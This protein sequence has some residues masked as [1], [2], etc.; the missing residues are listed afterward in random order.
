MSS[1]VS[2]IPE[3][4]GTIWEL[5]E[6]VDFE[7]GHILKGKHIPSYVKEY[8]GV[9]FVKTKEVDDD[10]FGVC[11]F[12]A[13]AGPFLHRCRNGNY[14]LINEAGFKN[15]DGIYISLDES[16]DVKPCIE[17]EVYR[18]VRVNPPK[19]NSYVGITTLDNFWSPSVCE[20]ETEPEKKRRQP[21]SGEPEHDEPDPQ[22]KR[23][24]V[25]SGSN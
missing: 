25:E 8:P 9:H 11:H 16:E 15:G 19:K 2:T 5:A 24:R 12:L 7:K 3:V 10:N 1:N 6:Y 20:D 14:D 21:A 23:R 22:T 4:I 18:I 17:T 13:A